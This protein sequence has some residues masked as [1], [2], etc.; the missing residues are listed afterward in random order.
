MGANQGRLPGRGELELRLRSS[1]SLTLW[2][3]VKGEPSEPRLAF[4]CAVSKGHVCAC[5]K[6]REDA[7]SGIIQL[8]EGREGDASQGEVR[9]APG[10]A[11]PLPC[12]PCFSSPPAPPQP[13]G[14]V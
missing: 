6:S 2:W 4:S 7:G 9:L 14:A 5:V 13:L 11:A 3:K 8:E 12:V 1:I 10:A